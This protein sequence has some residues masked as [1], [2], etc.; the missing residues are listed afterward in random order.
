MPFGKNKDYYLVDIPEHY[1]T[2]FQRKGFPNNTLGKLMAQMHD[3]KING[4][5][6]L[7]WN[8]KAQ[9]LK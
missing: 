2:W 3:I 7:I 1:Y 9:F 8:I 6:E 5:E 4:L